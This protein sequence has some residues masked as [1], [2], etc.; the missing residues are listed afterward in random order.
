MRSLLTAGIILLATFSIF[1]QDVEQTKKIP[2]TYDRSSL[3]TFFID[4]GSGN[5]YEKMKEKIDSIVFSDKYD[6]N[7]Y[8][9]KF[10]P[11]PYSRTDGP[12]AVT[13]AVL[14]ELTN[15]KVGKQI[16]AKWYNRQPDGNMS[17]DLIRSRGR[18]SATDADYIKAQT[19]KRGNAALEDFGNRLVNLSYVLLIDITKVQ[20]MEEAGMGDLLRGFQANVTG[21]LYKINFDETT[22]YAFYDTWIYDDDT[23]EVKAEKMKKFE[24]LEIPIS[25]ITQ[26]STVVSASQ[27]KSDGAKL[28]MKSKSDDDLLEELAQKCYDET[29][30]QI[31]REVEDFKVKTPI[32]E[33]RPIRAKIGLKEGLKTDYRFFVYEFVYNEKTGKPEPKQRG[34][35]RAKGKSKI[36]DNRKV[37]TGDMGTSQFYQVA[38]RKLEPGFILQ[39]QNDLGIEVLLA[40]EAGATGGI[41]ARADYRL[42]RFV[43][44]RALFVYGELGGGDSK[45]YQ[46][47]TSNFLRYG[48]GLAKGFQL[49][50][51][52]ELRPYAGAGMEQTT[53]DNILGGEQINSLYVRF[54]AN[55]AL[56]L[57]H[58]F[59]ICGGLGSYNYF[60]YATD[61][62]GNT[63]NLTWNDYF[64]KS[65][66]TAMFGV[67]VMF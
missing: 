62:D 42:G 50:R 28:F 61:S 29:I 18:F 47:E 10:I 53:N 7:N 17:L 64:D 27:P 12:K 21:Y 1:A 45:E 8:G 31:E 51:N 22:K 37:A 35:I 66:P 2:T 39:Q 67:K 14:S 30:F 26:K 34:V 44:I 63:E 25:F 59:Q 19:T 33:T 52:L 23:E 58:N 5:Y 3:A 15:R 65:G 13:E 55:L 24:E 41:L 9:E 20:T 43:G 46:N 57:K 32:Y 48:G 40:G 11:A 6:N 16:I 36:V 56:N 60:G 49:M 38:G 4:F 54:G